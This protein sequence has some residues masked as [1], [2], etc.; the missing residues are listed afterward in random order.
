MS[1]TVYTN[2]RGAC[3]NEWPSHD[4]TAHACR[5][6][7]RCYRKQEA[8]ITAPSKRAPQS[9]GHQLHK[10]FAKHETHNT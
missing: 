8:F 3:A 1:K 2:E 5:E 9:Y 7:L 10:S 6:N 4:P